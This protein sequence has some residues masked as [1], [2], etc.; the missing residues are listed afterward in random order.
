MALAAIEPKFFARFCELAGCPHLADKGMDTGDDGQ[1]VAAE[2]EA[3]FASRT[4]EAWVKLLGDDDKASKS[5]TR[6]ARDKCA[7][8]TAA[9]SSNSSKPSRHRREAN[10][11]DNRRTVIESPQS[12]RQ[13]RSAR[14]L[15]DGERINTRLVVVTRVALHNA[16]RGC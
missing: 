8:F 16:R 15:V 3:I 13:N 4:L 2:L 11:E 9:P 10:G 1:R 12:L 14:G 5:F 6:F 7:Q